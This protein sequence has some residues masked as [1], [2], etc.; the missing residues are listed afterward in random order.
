MDFD[1][2]FT[3]SNGD[4][5]FVWATSWGVSTRLMG[6][7]IMTHSDDLGL[8]LPPKLA[9][10][11]VVIVPNYKGSEQLEE[12]SKVANGIKD[13]LQQMGILVKYDNDDKRKPG[14]KFSEYEMK[15]V[16]LRIAIGPKDLA[17]NTVEIARRDTREKEILALDDLPNKV[18]HLLEAIQLNLFQKA[19]D[20][21]NEH[22][23]QADSLEEMNDILDN[24]GGFVLAHWD[25]TKES[26]I[27][28]KEKTKATIRCVQI[29]ELKQEGKC[30]FSGKKS[31][32]RVVF[33]RAY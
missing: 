20:F 22:T 13:S 16:P 2:T 25:G 5:K 27:K 28:I 14:W 11:H 31:S 10:I 15:G 17:N 30:I 7:L 6:A 12:V 33:A 4:Q 3:D 1:V 18:S 32:N 29:D 23:F 8:V 26:E 9:P 19:K 21:N 24:K